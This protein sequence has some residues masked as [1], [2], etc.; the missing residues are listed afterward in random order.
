MYEFKNG[1]IVFFNIIL[2]LWLS[3]IPFELVSELM[4][5]NFF[6]ISLLKTPFSL[7]THYIVMI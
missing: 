6:K 1:I 2:L 7:N 3:I 4:F 5:D